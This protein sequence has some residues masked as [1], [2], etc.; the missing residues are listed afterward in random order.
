MKKIIIIA[1]L[2]LVVG[3]TIGLLINSEPSTSDDKQL[4]EENTT[5]TCAMHPQIQMPEPGKCPICGMDLIPQ[6]SSNSGN[7]NAVV[8]QEGQVLQN[9]IQV[10]EVGETSAQKTIRLDGKVK[11]N[12]NIVTAQSAHFSG[13]I[14]KLNIQYEGQFVKQGQRIASIYSPE[15][16]KAQK[17]LLEALK[18]KDG[19]SGLYKA[20]R[21]KLASW[22][23]SESQLNQLEQDGSIT[24]TLSIFA[25]HT[26]VVTQLNIELGNYI[27]KGQQLYEVASL[28]SVWIEL[29]AYERD[30]EWLKLGQE[31]NLEIQS[32]KTDGYSGEISYI[33]PLLSPKTRTAKVRVKLENDGRLKPEMFAKGIIELG[34]MSEKVIAVPKSS[35]MWTGKRSIVYKEVEHNTF[36]LQEVT[37]G[38]NL[39]EH[40][41]ILAGLDRGDRIVKT[42]TFVVDAAAQ[43]QGKP[44]MMNKPKKAASAPKVQ[45]ANL[46]KLYKEATNALKSNHEK[47][48]KMVIAKL[49]DSLPNIKEKH[50]HLLHKTGDDF[51]MAF[52]NFSLDFY[53]DQQSKNNIYLINCPMVADNQGGY[54][55]DVEPI[56]DN[57]Y[58]GG[59]MKTCGSV[60]K[61]VKQ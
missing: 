26:G 42:G 40:Y 25:E 57:P 11:V 15:L 55:V 27:K 28:K 52:S 1:T 53:K 6:G 51:K 14:E 36:E 12:E 56:I 58:F 5:W 24:E 49:L 35:V 31:V 17:E 33:D 46:I 19:N 47:H 13:R 61:N 44:S 48:V 45:G 38:K 9:N 41:E 43:L 30:L 29:D 8:F 39:G 37:L 2:A 3:L 16:V 34:K 7:P 22:K 18:M 59:K 54:W 10:I 23:V 32:G 50:P 60:V 4:V 21:K 20:S